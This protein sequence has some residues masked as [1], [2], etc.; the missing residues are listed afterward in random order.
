MLLLFLG[1]L[2]MVNLPFDFT[3]KRVASGGGLG[4]VFF[5][6]GSNIG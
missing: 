3:E 2:F 6:V 4:G 1:L 5:L